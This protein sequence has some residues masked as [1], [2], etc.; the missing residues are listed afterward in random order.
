MAQFSHEL[1]WG[2]SACC[3]YLEITM[4][5][6]VIFCSIKESKSKTTSLSY[7]LTN[8]WFCNF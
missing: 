4:N 3:N 8:L 2:S 1:N 6:S 5:Y 7:P